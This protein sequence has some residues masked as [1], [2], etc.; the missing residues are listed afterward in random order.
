M[1]GFVVLLTDDPD[2][3]ESE[4][5]A[6]AEKHDIQNVPLTMFDGTA[7]PESYKVAEEADVTVHMWRDKKVESNHA[8]AE[9]QLDKSGIAKII[10][11]TSK[12][13]N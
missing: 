11:D 10:K 1:A 3:A 12:I 9:G 6:F 2:A 5:K 7:G 13:L 8:F 4:L